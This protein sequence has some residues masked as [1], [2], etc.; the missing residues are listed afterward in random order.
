M[1][2]FVSEIENE[3]SKI[4]IEL[5]SGSAEE[6]IRKLVR[7]GLAD[8]LTWLKPIRALSTGQRYRAELALMLEKAEAETYLGSSVRSGSDVCIFL[9]EF[10]SSLDEVTR[11]SI[12]FSIKRWHDDHPGVAIVIATCDHT[13]ER[14]LQPDVVITMRGLRAPKIRERGEN[15]SSKIENQESKMAFSLTDRLEIHDGRR[16]DY[17]IFAPL[18]YREGRLG[19]V[20]KVFLLRDRDQDVGIAVFAYPCIEHSLRTKLLPAH[21]KSDAKTKALWLNQNLRTLSRFVIDEPYRATGASSWFLKRCLAR[22]PGMWIEC[23][24]AMGRFTGF[25]ERSGFTRHGC[26]AP[27]KHARKV[28]EA[29]YPGEDEASLRGRCFR[30]SQ[31]ASDLMARTEDSRVVRAT[32]KF[33]Q[34][35]SERSSANR[36]A[37]ESV[38]NADA[39]AFVRSHAETLARLVA[40]RFLTHAEYFLRAS[41]DSKF[42]SECGS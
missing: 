20:Y 15:L 30:S 40:L 12:A 31:V 2:G 13:V 36:R 9:D 7:A 24:T 32:K 18:H 6:R 34:R 1:D 29:L 16:S 19:F 23:Q 22:M 26:V 14:D 5:V 21:A 25:L 39:A 41:P 11:K 28:L 38:Q 37:F 35:W 8:A 4:L 17:L 33:A 10:G 3:K 42:S 27:D